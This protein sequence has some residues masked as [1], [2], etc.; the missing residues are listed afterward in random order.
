VL[1]PTSTTN[2][3]T[4]ITTYRNSVLIYTSIFSASTGSTTTSIQYYDKHFLYTEDEFW[5]SEGPSFS[6]FKLSVKDHKE[7]K[8]SSC[9]CMDVNPYK[10][11]APFDAFEYGCFV[12]RNGIQVVLGKI[13]V[14]YMCFIYFV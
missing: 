4:T 13:Y 12:E 10:F 6:S 14:L 11:E 3:S 1:I 2:L 5:A 9:I 8:V 7:V